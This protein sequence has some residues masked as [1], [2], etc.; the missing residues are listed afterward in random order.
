[1]SCPMGGLVKGQAGGA[2]AQQGK[3]RA[4]SS[5]PPASGLT[6]PSLLQICALPI[7]TG[8]TPPNGKMAE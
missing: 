4:A 1:M 6:H 5:W 3:D 8:Q 2:E 7:P